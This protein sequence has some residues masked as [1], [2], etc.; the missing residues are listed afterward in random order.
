MGARSLLIK[1]HKRIKISIVKIGNQSQV[2]HSDRTLTSSRQTSKS[3][4]SSYNLARHIFTAP[5]INFLSYM[6]NVS[7]TLLKLKFLSDHFLV[8]QRNAF[9]VCF[10]GVMKSTARSRPQKLQWSTSTRLH[11]L[12]GRRR[13]LK[14]CSFHRA[15]CFILIK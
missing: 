9:E 2:A 11:F 3:L 10:S 8:F 12:S 7:C 14:K 4:S 13:L 6:I 1:D 5:S 15:Q